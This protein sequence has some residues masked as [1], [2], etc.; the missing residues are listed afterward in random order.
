MKI[1]IV[2]AGIAGLSAGQVLKENNHEVVLFDKNKTVGG[3]IRCETIEGN[4]YHKVGGHVFNS[5]HKEVLDWFWKFFSKEEEFLP[6]KRNAK[7][8]LGK[9]IVGYPIE[10]FLYQLEDRIVENIVSELLENQKTG[11]KNPLEFNNFKEFLVSNFG[12]TLYKIY[13]KPYNEK[14]WQTKLENVSMSWLSGKLPMPNYKEILLNSI[15]RKDDRKMVHS[16]FFYPKHNG[17]QFIANRLSKG[18]SLKLNKEIQSISLKDKKWII[19]NEVFDAIVYTGDVRRLGAFIENLP[20]KIKKLHAPVTSLNSH[21]TSNILCEINEYEDLSWLYLPN[22][23]L[24]P[25]RII[26][27]G[28]LSPNN[29]SKNRTCVVEFTGKITEKVM[30]EEIKKLPAKLK[31]IASNYEPYTYVIQEIETRENI[32][33]LQ[34]SLNSYNF[35]LH[36]R[37]AEWEYY[38]MDTVILSSLNKFKNLDFV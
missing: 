4:L 1:G 8:L 15:L 38:N 27:T 5:K 6:A 30:K 34:D 3:L 14:I 36:G 11:Y 32:S 31:P 9:D 17:S 29:N 7:I 22:K 19:D 28:N 2:G 18:L 23:D 12:E 35:Y 21:G 25:H 33:K 24:I 10:N 37:F 13:F 26:L 20:E 16:S